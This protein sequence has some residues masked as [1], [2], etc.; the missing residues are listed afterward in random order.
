MTVA[1]LMNAKHEPEAVAFARNALGKQVRVTGVWR[2]WSESGGQNTYEPTANLA[3]AA[4]TNPFHAFE[5][6]PITRVGTLS[7]LR[8]VNW[9][10]GYEAK[11]AL[12]AFTRYENLQCEISRTTATTTLKTVLAGYN[13]V[14]FVI[15]AQAGAQRTS[16]AWVVQASVYTLEGDL[17]VRNCRIVFVIGT[18]AGDAAARLT[19]GGRLRILGMPRLSLARLANEPAPTRLPYE[20]IAL[21][22]REV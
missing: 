18:N 7:V 12:T 5:V 13:Y 4:T 6:H 22:T 10:E 8:S 1:E 21:A 19:T 3:P 20:M 17:I 16:D 2:F 15:E 11:D 14:E 9:I